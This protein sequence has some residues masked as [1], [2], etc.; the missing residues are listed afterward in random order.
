MYIHIYQSISI[1]RNGQADSGARAELEMR[2][3]AVRAGPARCGSTGTG[4]GRLSAS[5]R[6]RAARG[7]DA[8]WTAGN[9]ATAARRGHRPGRE[10]T[11]PGAG[12]RPAREPG[13]K[14]RAGAN[15][16]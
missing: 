5:G 13:G 1:S 6:C 2:A 3:R 7:C 12:A 9:S 4:T 10:G 14:R 11:R 16:V 15:K 8:L